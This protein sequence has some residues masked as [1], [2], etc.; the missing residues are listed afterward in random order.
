MPWLSLRS[1]NLT[2]AMLASDASGLFFQVI[3]ASAGAVPLPCCQARGRLGS[4]ASAVPMPTMATP[5]ST[6]CWATGRRRMPPVTISGMLATFCTSRA[7][8]RK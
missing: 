1:W 6:T 5:L 3:G 4:M 8:S 2:R 7:N